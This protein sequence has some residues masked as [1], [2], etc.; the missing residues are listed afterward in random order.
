[1]L[2]YIINFRQC[3]G[4]VLQLVVI[5]KVEWAT[6]YVDFQK[7]GGAKEMGRGQEVTTIKFTAFLNTSKD[8]CFVTEGVCYRSKGRCNF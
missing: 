3:L 6:V 7:R 4:I 2:H 8:H 5:P 1:M